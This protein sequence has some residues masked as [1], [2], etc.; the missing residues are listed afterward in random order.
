MKRK[1]EGLTIVNTSQH[2]KEE[3][4]I[5]EEE[6]GSNLLLWVTSSSIVR[7]IRLVGLL[8]RLPGCRMEIDLDR[9]PRQA[10][11]TP[12]RVI[13]NTDTRP[14]SSSS[15]LVAGDSIR[16][17][18]SGHQDAGC[19]VVRPCCRHTI[20]LGVAITPPCQN[21]PGDHRSRC[22]PHQAVAITLSTGGGYRS[23]PPFAGAP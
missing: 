2:T 7:V 12:V 15:M 20:S 14:K 22:G 5:S 11:T 4:E 9:H 8:H 17:V 3:K 19:P 10:A 6:K 21:S 16:L 23:T 18:P 13:P 1:H